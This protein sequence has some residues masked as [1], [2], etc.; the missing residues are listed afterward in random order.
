M[1]YIVYILK[2]TNYN[3]FY[4]GLTSDLGERFE[5]HNGGRERTTRHYRPFSLVHK[6]EF[7]NRKDAR[8]YEKYLKIRSNKEKLLR[9]LGF[10]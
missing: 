7:N 10:L 1:E 9:T 3:W 2:S 4:V 5:R 8:E 6:R